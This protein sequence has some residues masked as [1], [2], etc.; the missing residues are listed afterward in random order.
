[1]QNSECR[2]EGTVHRQC[3]E[4]DVVCTCSNMIFESVNTWIKGYRCKFFR[5]CCFLVNFSVSFSFVGK[6]LCFGSA[7]CIQWVLNN[8][9]VVLEGDVW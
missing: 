4:D 5:A 6:R 1:M 3:R 8:R 9:L 2:V 7:G